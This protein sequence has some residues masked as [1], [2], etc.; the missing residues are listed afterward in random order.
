MKFFGVD[1]ET[2]ASSEQCWC[3]RRRRLA[4]K[5]F[6]GV[7]DEYLDG[8]GNAYSSQVRRRRRNPPVSGAVRHALV[9]VV[10]VVERIATHSLL[11]FNSFPVPIPADVVR[12][13]ISESSL[14][15]N[16]LFKDV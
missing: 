13:R 10:V 1:T 15:T 6:G 16:D 3:E 4:I 5:R 8:G 9:A 11:P 2:Q 7:K 14:V 12:V